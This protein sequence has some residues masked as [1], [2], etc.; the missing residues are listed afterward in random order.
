MSN[1]IFVHIP[2]TGGTTLN[3]A[4][5][6][7]YW[8]GKPDEFYRHI[9]DD[10]TSNSGDI[11][12]PNLNDKYLGKSIFMFVR[13]PIDRMI[14]E[15]YF[16]KERKEFMD[17]IKPKPMNFEAYIN[18]RQ[19]QNYMIGFLKGKRMYD[20]KF[21][22]EQD[23]SD[24]IAAI[25]KLD[26]KVGIFEKYNDSLAYFSKELNLVLPK[27]MEVKRITLKR[28]KMDELDQ[29]TTSLIVEK[30][31]LD[32][33]LYDYCL[34]RFQKE[35]FGIKGDFQFKGDKFDHVIAFAARACFYEFCVST[36][37]FISNNFEFFKD[38]TFHLLEGE[39]MRDGR[40]F[41]STWN[42]TFLNHLENKFPDSGLVK[43]LKAETIYNA[44]PVEHAHNIGQAIDSYLRENP[45]ERFGGLKL[46]HALIIIQQPTKNTFLEKLFGKKR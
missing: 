5:L 45:H 37:S 8:Q 10:K 43:S 41:A 24:V 42:S 25:E 9:L 4:I 32:V 22:T 46:N 30:N 20:L 14:S 17:L 1:A 38:L 35:S 27:E 11:F 26:I 33:Q 29:A 16:I 44:D 6:G 23:L 31:Q 3:S 7:K 36:K 28:P 34:K 2:K 18:S 13:N 40:L 15:Y 21:V 39:K 12:D 19:T